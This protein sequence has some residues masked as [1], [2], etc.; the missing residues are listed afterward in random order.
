MPKC[1]K[2]GCENPARGSYC[3]A[4]I[5]EVRTCAVEGCP[6]RLGAHNRRGYCYEHRYIAQKLQRMLRE[7]AAEEAADE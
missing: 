3:E 1:I 4:H 5:T 2:D 6:G 7:A